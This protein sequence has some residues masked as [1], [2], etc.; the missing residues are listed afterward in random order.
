MWP[1]HNLIRKTRIAFHV[2]MSFIAI[3]VQ[4]SGLRGHF[5]FA[6]RFPHPRFFRI[7]TFSPRN[8]V[9]CFRLTSPEAIDLEF[10]GWIRKAYAVGQQRHLHPRALAK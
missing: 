7:D 10:I 4:K 9:H 1:G 3:S 6:R 5:V 8:H 2:R